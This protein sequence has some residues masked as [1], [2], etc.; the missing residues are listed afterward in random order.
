MPSGIRHLVFFALSIGIFGSLILQQT[1]DVGSFRLNPVDF[2]QLE[3]QDLVVGSGWSR[4]QEASIKLGF[5]ESQPPPRVGV[6]GNHQVQYFSAKSLPEEPPPEEFFNFWYANLSLTE[7]R[8]YVAYVDSLD[9]LPRDLILVHITTP[10]NDN[11]GNILGYQDELP[12][13][14]HRFYERQQ[15]SGAALRST[16]F[17]AAQLWSE[18][19]YLVDWKTLAA[20]ILSENRLAIVDPTACTELDSVPARAE[21]AVARIL[22][23]LAVARA[24]PEE[25]RSENLRDLCSGKPMH[26]I[27][28]DGSAYSNYNLRALVRNEEPVDGPD[29]KLRPGDEKRIA[30]QMRDVAAIAERR[31]RRLAFLITPVHETDRHSPSDEIMS[32][33]LRQVP[34][35]E[36][37][38]HRHQFR[39]AEYF[40]DYDH[41]NEKYF[42]RVVEELRKRKLL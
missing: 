26:V 33:A 21:G 27:R 17:R 10:N 23:R 39:Q 8:D 36:V 22:G 18:L 6:F 29:Q 30:D 7:L 42:E 37:L 34:E 24:L 1:L 3:P 40:V 20:G 5:I 15:S 25:R 2:T 9:K 41:P 19:R 31:G 35:L 16:Y 14:I 4:R 28:R 13:D 11:G 32:A 38:D 12:E